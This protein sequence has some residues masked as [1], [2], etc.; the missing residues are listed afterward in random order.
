MVTS[1]LELF[2][3]PCVAD[4]DDSLERD[5]TG[6]HDQDICIVVLLDQLADFR[7]PAESRTDSLVLVEGDADAVS[8]AAECDSE[9]YL[10]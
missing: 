8:S 7:R 4:L 6:W 5:E 1:S 9:V 10:T 3:Q 2:I